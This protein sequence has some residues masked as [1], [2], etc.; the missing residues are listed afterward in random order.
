VPRA[1]K[2]DVAHEHES[3]G[4]RADFNSGAQF[5]GFYLP[6]DG[7]VPVRLPQA[8]GASNTVFTVSPRAQELPRKSARNR[9]RMSRQVGHFD[10][11]PK[12]PPSKIAVR[13]ISSQV[14]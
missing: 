7:R 10:A 13:P 8:K 4:G 1:L 12:Y 5:A 9:N 2:P 11:G 3:V 14:G 6:F